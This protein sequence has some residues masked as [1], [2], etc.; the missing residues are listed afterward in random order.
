MCFS[1]LTFPLFP[2][3]YTSI[4]SLHFS[5]KIRKRPSLG[6]LLSNSWNLFLSYSTEFCSRCGR[7]LLT[8]KLAMSIFILSK[9]AKIDLRGTDNTEIRSA[10]RPDVA[11]TQNYTFEEGHWYSPDLKRSTMSAMSRSL[12][13]SSSRHGA[14]KAL[15]VLMMNWATLPMSSAPFS[16]CCWMSD[17]SS[18]SSIWPFRRVWYG[19]RKDSRVWRGQKK[20]RLKERE[21]KT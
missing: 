17:R 13:T 12:Q 15:M 10:Q 9:T 16:A 20:N 4:K 11:S 2:I 18:A 19:I 6:C 14:Q 7:R 8:A 5:K 3:P 1:P 21:N